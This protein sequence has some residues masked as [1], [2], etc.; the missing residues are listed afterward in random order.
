MLVVFIFANTLCS[1]VSEDICMYLLVLE[2]LVI[3]V[4]LAAQIATLIEDELT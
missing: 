4:A 3:A 2:V 1:H